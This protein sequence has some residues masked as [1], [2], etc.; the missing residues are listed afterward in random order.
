MILN[1]ENTVGCIY[2]PD[3]SEVRER[4]S[5]R[6]EFFKSSIYQ[7]ELLPVYIDIVDL[8]KIRQ[9]PNKLSKFSKN[10]STCS[11]SCIQQRGLISLLDFG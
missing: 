3:A 11:N 7:T 5:L 1:R 6:T 8:K 10:K 4:A 9:I 2:F